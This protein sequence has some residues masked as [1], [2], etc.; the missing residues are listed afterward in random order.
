MM[1]IPGASGFLYYAVAAAQR[2]VLFWDTLRGRGNESLR[3]EAAGKPPLLKF[4]HELLLDG[5][6]LERHCNHALLRILPRSGDLPTDPALRP[7]VVVD[8]R[9]AHGPG[10]AASRRTAR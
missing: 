9:A 1:R 3:H 4:G 5:R 10:S 6:A 8:P 7:F 2:S